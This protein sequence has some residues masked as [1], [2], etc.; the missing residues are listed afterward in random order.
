VRHV[1][2][3]YR[4]QNQSDNKRLKWEFFCSGC[5]DWFPAKEVQVE[6][7]DATGP[8][9]S[10]ETFRGFAEKLFV[11]ADGL[12]LHCESC[13]AEKTKQERDERK[14]VKGGA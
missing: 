2:H 1:W 12:T 11:E 8:L 4:R 5:G 13:H 14:Q 10:W 9:N 3:R 7:R 6:H